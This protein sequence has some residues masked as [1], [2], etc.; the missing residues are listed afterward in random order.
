MKSVDTTARVRREHFIRHRFIHEISRALNVSRNTVSKILRS[1]AI[2]FQYERKVQPLPTIGPWREQ[3]ELNETGI[4][5]AGKI[6]GYR[7]AKLVGDHGEWLRL[8]Q[9]DFSL[10]GLV[11]ELGERGCQVD[12]KQSGNLCMLKI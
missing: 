5:A 2:E 10:R 9:L 6:G 3:L 11:G 4:V 8:H 12:Y 7:P 1:G